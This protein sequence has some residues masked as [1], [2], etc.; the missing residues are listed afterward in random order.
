[1]VICFAPDCKHFSDSHTCRYFGFPNKDK[2]PEEYQRWVR[3]IRREDREP[4]K[5]SR[6]C[7]CHFRNGKKTNGPEIF[8][9]NADISITGFT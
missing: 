8:Q 7:S 4:N 1:M 9:R 5:H 6:I 2:K 3:L